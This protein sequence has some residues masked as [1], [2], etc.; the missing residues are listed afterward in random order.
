MADW[1]VGECVA[2][3]R[4]GGEDISWRVLDVRD[5]AA[6]LLSERIVTS[7]PFNGRGGPCS[8]SESGIRRW[9][10]GRFLHG[11]FTD[12]ERERILLVGIANRGNPVTG[13]PAGPDTEDSAFCL[14]IAEA[15]TL[16]GGRGWLE[17]EPTAHALARRLR[18]SGE[19]GFDWW[20]RS[21][22]EDASTAA[23]VCRGRIM[24]CGLEVQVRGI[25]VRPAM[26]V[27]LER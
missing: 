23:D 9:L 24:Y 17:A 11:A 1:E 7:I 6:L 19:G 25:G 12:W 5:G 18:K 3:G 4:Y 16:L 2:F 27:R 15:E 13:A 14:S 20:L 21:P 22:G 26:W 8:W 10:N